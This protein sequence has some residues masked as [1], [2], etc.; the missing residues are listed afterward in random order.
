MTTSTR[1]AF[2]R[3]TSD[4]RELHPRTAMSRPRKSCWREIRMRANL[5][6][7][8][9]GCARTWPPVAITWHR[10][11]ATGPRRS[12]YYVLVAVVSYPLS[13]CQ[14]MAAPA[15]CRLCRER[16]P[17]ASPC[18]LPAAG[19]LRAV[20]ACFITAALNRHASATHLLQATT[21][22]PCRSFPAIQSWP[23]R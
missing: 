18:G 23:P 20:F 8:R 12:F 19:K 2:S 1:P 17:V 10:P 14:T 22:A 3:A 16:L 7:G 9:L 15:V 13:F 5:V 21:F 11:S 4:L 6:I